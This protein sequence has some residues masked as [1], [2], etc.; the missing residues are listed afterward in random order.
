M[1][2]MDAEEEVE[3]Y[4][5]K[6]EL[7][8]NEIKNYAPIS[9]NISQQQMTLTNPLE[10]NRV[11]TL[12]SDMTLNRKLLVKK[13]KKTVVHDIPIIKDKNRENDRLV[14]ELNDYLTLKKTKNVGKFNLKPIS[15]K[16]D[17]V[18]SLS[19][20]QKINQIAN[21]VKMNQILKSKPSTEAGVEHPNQA[22]QRTFLLVPQKAFDPLKKK[23][24]L[25]KKGVITN[26]LQSLSESNS[27]AKNVKQNG[28]KN[29]STQLSNILEDSKNFVMK[30]ADINQPEIQ[31]PKKLSDQQKVIQF[32]QQHSLA[33]N[34]T[35][36]LRKECNTH[37]SEKSRK[38]PM[39]VTRK[40]QLQELQSL[41]NNSTNSLTKECSLQSPDSVG[42]HVIKRTDT[43]EL[44][45]LESL[46]NNSAKPLKQGKKKVVVLR[47]DPYFL[48][49]KPFVIKHKPV[50]SKVK[51]YKSY[52]VDDQ[53]G[54][55]SNSEFNVVSISEPSKSLE[56]IK[57]EMPEEDVNIVA[58]Q[59]NESINQVQ[60][61][62]VALKSTDSDDFE[63]LRLEESN[64]IVTEDDMQILGF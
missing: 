17:K 62:P 15:N 35:S 13:K 63:Y 44:D 60:V 48:K 61:F 22:S 14:I 52:P 31:L 34:S 53:Q 8:F 38:N 20:V 50:G 28:H 43:I 40:I 54:N 32:D 37:S 57:F 33:S 55:F 11:I 41:L 9:V 5:R 36:L 25:I 51:K 26:K 30:I 4:L 29:S 24:K 47:A 64:E 7:T 16:C 3:Q 6:R 19:P 2:K 27:T 12:D 56:K 49:H 1:V 46:L 23:S 39:K 58:A 18:N 42:N 10:S 21:G 59:G 45:Q